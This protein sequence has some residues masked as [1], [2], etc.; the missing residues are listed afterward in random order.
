[1]IYPGSEVA[2][3]ALIERSVVLPGAV[4]GPHARL[5]DTVVPSGEVVD[6]A[7]SGIAGIDSR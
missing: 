4:V 1:V 7:R 2:D 5:R 6:D 3:G